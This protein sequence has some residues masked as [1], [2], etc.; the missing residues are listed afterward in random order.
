MAP[1]RALLGVGLGLTL[2]FGSACDRRGRSSVPPIFSGI[3]LTNQAGARLG[4]AELTGNVLLLNLMFTSC[5]SVCPA[6]T[7]ALAEVRA[8]LP[9][10]V[11]ERT[12]FVSL[13][14]DP[15]NDDAPALQRFARAH[16]ADQAGWQFVRT[17]AK[18]TEVLG[19]RLSAFDPGSPPT[20]SAHG[21]TLYLFDRGGRLVQRYRGAPIQVA[22]LAREIAA[23]DDLKPSEARLASN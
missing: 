2:A 7:R 9:A 6:Q 4:P 5:P 16:G 1:R 20:P 19:A 15:D 10:A 11:R 8:L 3:S 12:R 13:S 18:S 21:T 17:D 14:V 23:L 22:H